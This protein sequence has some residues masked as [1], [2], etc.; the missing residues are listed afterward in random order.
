MRGRRLL[1]LDAELAQPDRQ[2]LDALVF[3]L[4]DLTTGERAGVYE[5]LHTLVRARLAKG[6]RTA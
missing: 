2:A 1:K 4:L 5:A 3:D 6:G